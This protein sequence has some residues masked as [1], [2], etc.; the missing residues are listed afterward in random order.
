[1]AL[2]PV[3]TELSHIYLLLS[4]LDITSAN[5]EDGRAQ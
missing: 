2:M 4:R 3:D 5:G 1:M